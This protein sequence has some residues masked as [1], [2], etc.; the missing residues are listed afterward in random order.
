[1]VYNID[2]NAWKQ[3][4]KLNQGR[5]QHGSC[6]F[7][8]RFVYIFAGYSFTSHVGDNPIE[9]I[10]LKPPPAQRPVKWEVVM[11]KSDL[12]LPRLCMPSVVQ[13]SSSEI[14][15]AGGMKRD[16]YIFDVHK[17]TLKKSATRAS[18]GMET[19]GMLTVVT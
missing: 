3:L 14:S 6:G 13:V 4:P 19:D 9:M 11:L 15:I 17:K 18:F 8:G 7:K 1:M 12:T 5:Y 2:K 16:I 10:N